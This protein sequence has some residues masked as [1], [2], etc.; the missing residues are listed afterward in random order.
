MGL[1]TPVSTNPAMTLG[2]LT[3]GLTPLELAFAY[4]T[5]ANKGRRVSGSL[6]SSENGPVAIRSVKGAGRDITNEKRETRVFSDSVGDLTQGILSG[7]VSSGTGK[8]AQIG[9]FAAGKTGTTENYGDAWFVG[10]NNELTVAVWVGYPDELRSMETEYHG[11]PVAGGTFP[12]EIWHD[13]MTS[14]IGIRDAR[15]A[16]RA[17][18]DEESTDGYVPV[19]PSVQSAP[20]EP[21]PEDGGEA[22]DAPGD[23]TPTPDTPAEPAP[24]PDP[25]PVPTPTPAPPP[26]SPPP[27]TGGGGATGGGAAPG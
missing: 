9:E 1:K 10:F 13:L 12:A 11:G 24:T 4:S 18:D 14:W 25:E 20:T 19:D 23:Q 17:S 26:T 21:A 22:P 15:E 27:P 3:E 16:A 6:A 2:G 7:V 5:I 8:A